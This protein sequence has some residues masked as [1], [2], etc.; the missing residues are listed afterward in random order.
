[1][2]KSFYQVLMWFCPVNDMIELVSGMPAHQVGDE[3]S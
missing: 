3:S 2:I 1:M